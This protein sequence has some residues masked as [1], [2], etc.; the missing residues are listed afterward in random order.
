MNVRHTSYYGDTL[1]C[2][3]LYDYVKEQKSRVQNTKP[4][5]KLCTFDLEVKGQRRINI[6]NVRDTSSEGD[7]PMCQILYTNFKQT[8]VTGRTRRHDENL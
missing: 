8:E 1:T 7:R 5:H 3:T 6:M 2:K 4:C